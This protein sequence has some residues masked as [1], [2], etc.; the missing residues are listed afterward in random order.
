MIT[1]NMVVQL[2]HGLPDQCRDWFF[3]RARKRWN[4]RKRELKLYYEKFSTHTEARNNVPLNLGIGAADWLKVTD[5]FRHANTVP[6]VDGMVRTTHINFVL[7][8]VVSSILTK[9][10]IFADKESAHT[11]SPCITTRP[12]SN[13]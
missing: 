13:G 1:N 5:V 2:Q 10:V 12:Y 8:S 7:Y 9:K 4:A 11:E 3:D 6:G